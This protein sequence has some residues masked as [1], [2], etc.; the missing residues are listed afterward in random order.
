MNSNPMGAILSSKTMMFPR[1]FSNLLWCGIFL[2]IFLNVGCQ[3]SGRLQEGLIAHWPLVKNF[4]ETA[5]NDHHA[6]E[7]E[8]AAV[9]EGSSTFDGKGSWLQAPLSLDE[10]IEEFSISVWVDADDKDDDISGDILSWYDP[11]NRRGFHLSLKTNYVTTSQAN[12][13]QL[14]FGIDDNIQSSWVN[15]GKPGNALVAFSLIDFEGN[16]YAGT[17]EPGS[18]EVGHVYR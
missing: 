17:C 4:E 7:H 16:L 3:S 2:G 1:S 6:V 18:K 5:G 8:N 11:Q 14:M 10:N 9:L 13:R 15:C 12:Y